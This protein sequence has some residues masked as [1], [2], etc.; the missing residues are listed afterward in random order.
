[1][2]LTPKKRQQDSKSGWDELNRELK[3]GIDKN[4][5]SNP[6]ITIDLNNYLMG[7]QEIIFELENNDYQVQD[8]GDYL[9][10]S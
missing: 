6:S 2:G 4:R 8:Q 5:K 7:K 10:I 9:R 3:F 1:M